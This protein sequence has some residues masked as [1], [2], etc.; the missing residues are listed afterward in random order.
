M[1]EM[2]NVYK[3]LGRKSQRGEKP[4]GTSKPIWVDNIKMHLSKLECDR[5]LKVAAQG[6]DFMAHPYTYIHIY[7][8]SRV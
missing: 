1:C 7:I 2:M 8:Q 3:N 4:F 6:P 5:S